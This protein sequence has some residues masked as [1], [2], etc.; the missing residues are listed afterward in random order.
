MI[1]AALTVAVAVWF[2]W[3][4]R[5]ARVRALLVTRGAGDSP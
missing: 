2:G 5:R 4:V 1:A 3:E